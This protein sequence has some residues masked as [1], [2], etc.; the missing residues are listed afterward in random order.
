MSREKKQSIIVYFLFRVAKSDTRYAHECRISS[1]RPPIAV[2]LRRVSI[3]VSARK[4]HSQ[5]SRLPAVATSIFEFGRCS[6]DAYRKR[7][8]DGRQYSLINRMDCLHVKQVAAGCRQA[9]SV[10]RL[11][12]VWS[13][14]RRLCAFPVPRC[15][16]TVLFWPLPRL[17]LDLSSRGE[18]RPT[19]GRQILTS[20]ST[21]GPWQILL[22]Y[23][24][25]IEASIKRPARVRSARKVI[26]WN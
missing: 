20:L 4:C 21:N 13:L 18:R 12:V 26:A 9:N 2:H 14:S 6:K 22:S 25:R 17:M 5:T 19:A 10:L 1:S 24:L 23:I 15:L 11:S 8:T 7:I 3:V 16:L